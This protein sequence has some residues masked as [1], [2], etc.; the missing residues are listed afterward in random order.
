MLPYI[1]Y[2]CLHHKNPS[3]LNLAEGNHSQ[4]SWSVK[5][6]FFITSSKKLIQALFLDCHLYNRLKLRILSVQLKF[7]LYEYI[8]TLDN[9]LFVFIP[10]QA[11][12]FLL[13]QY[14]CILHLLILG[15]MSYS[16]FV[17]HALDPANC[18]VGMFF[19]NFKLLGIS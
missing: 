12:K 6:A 3:Y 9:N 11:L 19:D 1:L 18:E 10:I 15:C 2:L 7:P 13:I 14:L 8:Q 4:K 17:E 16:I 5:S